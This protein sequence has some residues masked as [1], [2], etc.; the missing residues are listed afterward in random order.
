M[1]I[2]HINFSAIGQMAAIE[3]SKASGVQKN[4]SM[5]VEFVIELTRQQGFKK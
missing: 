3:P 1:G 2:R 4:K 5:G